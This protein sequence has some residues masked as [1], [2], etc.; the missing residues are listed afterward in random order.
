MMLK[1]WLQMIFGK[2]GDKVVQKMQEWAQIK[3]DTAFDPDDS[4]KFLEQL[5]R[6][7]WTFYGNLVDGMKQSK[8]KVTWCCKNGL[9]HE[10]I[11]YFHDN[12]LVGNIHTKHL[13]KNGILL[14]QELLFCKQGVLHGYHLSWGIGSN[15]S[16]FGLY[17]NGR[18][19]GAHWYAFSDKDGVNGS[20]SFLFKANNM[21][22]ETQ[23]DTADENGAFIYPDLETALVGCFNVADNTLL[24]ASEATIGNVNVNSFGIM[25][26]HFDKTSN[27]FF[28]D[29]EYLSDQICHHPTT[30]DPYEDKLVNVKT[31]LIADAGEGLFA[32][33]NIQ[34]GHLL[35][36][37][38]A[39][40]LEN[41]KGSD[42]SIS[43]HEFMMDIPEKC[44][45]IKNYCATLAHKICH[46]FEPNADYSYAFHPR[47]GRHIRCAVAIKNI[48]IGEEITCNY[49]YKLEKAPEWYRKSLKDHLSQS[50]HMTDDIIEE[51]MHKC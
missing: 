18:K 11:G 1:S 43:C 31:S 40:P 46:S 25:E 30:K 34:K 26:P 27:Y 48:D 22:T 19:H 15:D 6:D 38:H 41:E 35:A 50:L 14:S 9:K 16:S 39:I 2:N 24:E 29:S 21:M 47:F 3:L 33:Q 7:S 5:P 8:G 23:D 32:K 51:V 44:R 49:K 45:D 4:V 37:F 13:D 28:D 17:I 36:F 42:Y 10:L 12:E 20:D